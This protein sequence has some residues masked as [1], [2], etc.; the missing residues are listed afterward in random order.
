MK[1]K[2]ISLFALIL[3]TT[4]VN[5]YHASAYAVIPSGEAVG[6][7]IKTE[8][9]LVTGITELTDA[10]GLTVNAAYKAGIRKGDRIIAVDG[11]SV[12]TIEELANHIVSGPEKIVLTITRDKKTIKISTTPVQTKNGYKLGVWVRDS[13][14]GIGT[15]TYIDPNN[16][17]FAA[18]GHGICD[19]DTDDILTIRE[20]NIQRC[21]ISNP[22][23]GKRGNPGELN[24]YFG[25]ESIGSIH[26]NSYNGI[27]G[28]CSITSNS[29]QVEIALP[30]EIKRSKAYILANVDGQGVKS[31]EV[32]IKKISKHTSGDKNLVIEVVDPALIKKTGGI[33]QGMSG[34]PILQNGKLI[35]AVTHV[36]VNN[37]KQGYGIF[38]TNMLQENN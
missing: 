25:E 34:A 15:V 16:N 4:S 31:Y 10:S 14:A 33:V 24:G 13:T 19:V 9:V 18:L 38:A 17:T 29:Q 30:E 5:I 21:N 20:G 32:E 6:V 23:K 7:I 1:R 12:N 27:F 35:G 3:C 22:T 8:G 2:F 28:Q 36:F 37:P 11:K 26:T